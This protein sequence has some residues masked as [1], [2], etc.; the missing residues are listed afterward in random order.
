MSNQSLEAV[1]VA[2]ERMRAGRRLAAEISAKSKAPK[3]KRAKKEKA[4]GT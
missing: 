2:V 3:P 1:R 4:S